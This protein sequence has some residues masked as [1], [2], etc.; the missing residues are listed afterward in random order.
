[1]LV[2]KSTMNGLILSERIEKRILILRGQRVMLSMDLAE[3]YQVAPKVLAQ[4]VKRNIER[5]PSDFMFQLDFQEVSRSRS[6]FVTLKRGQNVKYLPY[7][8][9]EQGVA[10]LSSILKSKRA[11]QVNIEIMRAFVRLRELIAS[12]KDLAK[13]LEELEQ[14]YDGQFKVVFDAI[15]QLMAPPETK[16]HRIGFRAR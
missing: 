7:A 8:F 11:V 16:P 5:F 6:Q 15:R 9:T 4:T 14:K 10:M 12:H 2:S 1:M 3:L 13:K